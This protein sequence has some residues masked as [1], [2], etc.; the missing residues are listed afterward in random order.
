MS[1]S[2]DLLVKVSESCDLSPDLL[3]NCVFFTF[4]RPQRSR[5]E[6]ACK[7]R[8]ISSGNVDGESAEDTSVLGIPASCTRGELK[9]KLAGLWGVVEF[10]AR[11]RTDWRGRALV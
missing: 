5:K 9:L 6:R 7:F 10:R 11:D 4:R 3:F 2:A 8:Q 1:E